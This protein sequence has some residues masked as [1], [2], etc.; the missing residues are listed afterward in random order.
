MT[1]R[2]TKPAAADLTHICDY[3]KERFGA[4][5]A[6]SAALAIYDAAN[7]LRDMPRRG[8]VGR[9][10]GTRELMIP[11]LPFVVIYRVGKEAVEIVR[12]LHGAQQWP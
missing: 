6:R 7:S 12:I 9:K 11:D 3:T 2:W 8:R 1:V 4:V 10:P 5:Q